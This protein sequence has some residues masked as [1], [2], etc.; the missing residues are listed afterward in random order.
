MLVENT[1]EQDVGQK[2]IQR[3]KATVACNST[4]AAKQGKTPL[5]AFSDTAEG[6]SRIHKKGIMEK[7]EPSGWAEILK[8]KEASEESL[9]GDTCR[10]SG[11]FQIQESSEQIFEKP[12]MEQD[13]VNNGSLNRELG[14]SN[15]T[16]NDKECNLGLS[17]VNNKNAMATEWQ[18][19]SRQRR[20]QKKS[21]MGLY[22]STSRTEFNGSNLQTHFIH[23]M[24]QQEPLC[25]AIVE[26]NKTPNNYNGQKAANQE[27]EIHQNQEAANIWNKA[28]QLGVSGVEEQSMIIEQ[29][30][31]MEERDKEGAERRGDSTRNQ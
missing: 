23:E 27:S 19:Y 6:A 5:L 1:E 9:H 16:P 10:P 18:V 28:K 22:A 7:G 24:V 30:K 29:I 17:P 11:N 13:N 31:I 26:Q 20:G 8:S 14:L 15:Y 2:A 3:R 12:L 4:A 21:Q 25:S